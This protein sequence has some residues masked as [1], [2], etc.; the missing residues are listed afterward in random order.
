MRPAKT[1]QI[2]L[3]EDSVIGDHGLLSVV[4]VPRRVGKLPE[5]LILLH[6]GLFHHS[7]DLLAAPLAMVRKSVRSPAHK[8]VAPLLEVNSGRLRV[9]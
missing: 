3:V 9:F 2:G 1:G 7:L 5:G 8:I 6:F 4:C